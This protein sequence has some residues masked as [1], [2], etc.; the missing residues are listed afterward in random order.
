MKEKICKI[1]NPQH[2]NGYSTTLKY[3]H[4]A[5]CDYGFKN[6]LGVLLFINHIMLIYMSFV[7]LVLLPL[8]IMLKYSRF[9]VIV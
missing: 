3:I 5:F 4:Y 2:R 1:N 6:F 9:V 8:V 7:F